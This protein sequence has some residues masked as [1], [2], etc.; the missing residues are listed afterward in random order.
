MASPLE[1]SFRPWTTEVSLE[2]GRAAAMNIVDF[3]YVMTSDSFP[4]LGTECTLQMRQYPSSEQE[5]RPF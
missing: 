4:E 5:K 2:V 1:Y 3:G